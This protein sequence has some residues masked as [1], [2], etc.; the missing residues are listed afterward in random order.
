MTVVVSA[1][2]R[3]F[4]PNKTFLET[5]ESENA[6]PRP[7]DKNKPALPTW[8]AKAVTPVSDWRQR[9]STKSWSTRR[10]RGV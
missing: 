6:L 4:V 5:V 7:I 1:G 2:R 9:H 8:P 10:L 3:T